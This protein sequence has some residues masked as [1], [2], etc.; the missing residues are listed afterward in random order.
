MCVLLIFLF[1]FGLVLRLILRSLICNIGS[2]CGE[3]RFM[4]FVGVIRRLGGVQR[5]R[6]GLILLVSWGVVISWLIGRV[7]LGLILQFG[8]P[9]RNSWSVWIPS[10]KGEH[11]KVH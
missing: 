5:S 1:S 11:R 6:L 4:G 9:I 7:S 8:L 3:V 10:R 2:I